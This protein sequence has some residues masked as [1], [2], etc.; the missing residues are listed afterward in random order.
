MNKENRKE[1]KRI[2][3]KKRESKK[4]VLH[5]WPLKNRVVRLKIY[6]CIWFSLMVKF[7]NAEAESPF[8]KLLSFCLKFYLNLFNSKKFNKSNFIAVDS[9]HSHANIH[10]Q[11]HIHG[12]IY[13]HIVDS[14]HSTRNTRNFLFFIL[15]AQCTHNTIVLR[16]MS[17]EMRLCSMPLLVFNKSPGKCESF[18]KLHACISHS[19]AITLLGFRYI[20]EFICVI[21]FWRHIDFGLV[22]IP[23]SDIWVGDLFS[24]FFVVS[25]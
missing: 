5:K 1:W 3:G 10:T 2:G 14:G 23:C 8:A 13:M 17:T 15:C 7:K 20:S 22:L 24:P 18:R 4:A 9:T 16:L 25:V 19:I 12:T 6:G 21:P 11:T